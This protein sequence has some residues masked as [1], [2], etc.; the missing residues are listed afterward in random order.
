MA[1]G[2]YLMKDMRESKDP[3]VRRIGDKTGAITQLYLPLY[4]KDHYLLGFVVMSYNHK[5][6]ITKSRISNI[7]RS[8]LQVES[9]L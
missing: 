4:S 1:N 3:L 2:H 7:R 8:V 6:D 9:L 5:E